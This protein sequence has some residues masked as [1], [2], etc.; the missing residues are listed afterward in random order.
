MKSRAQKVVVIRRKEDGLY[1]AASKGASDPKWVEAVE[2]ANFVAPGKVK[3]LIR[4]V[5][6]RDLEDYETLE[7]VPV[8]KDDPQNAV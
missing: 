6:G 1:Y 8:L 4:A 2:G 5:W 3:S 7:V